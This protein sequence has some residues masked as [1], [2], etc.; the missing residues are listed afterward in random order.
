M[1]VLKYTFNNTTLPEPRLEGLCCPSP[2]QSSCREASR[3][4]TDIHL[5]ELGALIIQ[6]QISDT[7]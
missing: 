1:S 6:K 7:H 3:P 4:A 5:A 2:L